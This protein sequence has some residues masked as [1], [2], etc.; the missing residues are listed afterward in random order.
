M[1]VAG[2][3]CLGI[4]SGARETEGTY[5]SYLVEGKKAFLVAFPFAFVFLLTDTTPPNTYPL[6]RFYPDQWGF[7]YLRSFFLFFLT[8]LLLAILLYL[9]GRIILRP[10][11]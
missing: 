1:D 4:S 7:F 11:A 9:V 8:A 6:T 3:R 2:H 5:S 10:R